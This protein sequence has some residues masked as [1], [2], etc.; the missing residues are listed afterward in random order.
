MATRRAEFIENLL[1]SA[2]PTSDKPNVTV[3]AL[4]DSAAQELD[5]KLGGEPLVEASTLGMIANTNAS[6]GR[7]PEALAASDRELAI[8][9]AQGGSE[10]MAQHQ[11]L[12]VLPPRLPPG[13]VQ[14]RH[15]TG[16]M[17]KISFKSTSRKSSHG[18]PRANPPPTA[19]RGH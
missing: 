12:S 13:Q 10:L 16:D 2:D 8:L 1:A 19:T 4:L 7:Y 5:H 11:D 3:A 14:H 15:G 18:R 17:R 6:L 9:R